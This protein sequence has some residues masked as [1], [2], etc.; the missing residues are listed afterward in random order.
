MHFL[1]RYEKYSFR[2]KFDS[3]WNGN[4]P[5]YVRH[6]FSNFIALISTDIENTTQQIVAW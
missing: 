5:W 4:L 2:K 1:I 6:F 3:F